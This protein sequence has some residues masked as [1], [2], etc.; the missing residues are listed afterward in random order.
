MAL[1]TIRKERWFNAGARALIRATNGQVKDRYRCPTCL[2]D[3]EL[4]A[5]RTGAITE[6]DVPPR[7]LGGRPMLLTCRPCNNTAGRL[8][9]SN[10]DR[11]EDQIRF[12]EGETLP[13]PLRIR[14]RV[15]EAAIRANL[16]GSAASGYIIEGV[17]A[18]NPP[19][20]AEVFG[21]A[22]ESAGVS[23]L[24][25]NLEFEQ[26]WHQWGATLCWVRAA[27]LLAFAAFGYRYILERPEFDL[28]RQQ[29]Q[30]PGEKL[31]PETSVMTAVG[32][33]AAQTLM[34]VEEPGDLNGA[35]FVEVGRR[36]VLLPGL[37]ADPAFFH[38]THQALRAHGV[39]DGGMV[40]V[41]LAGKDVPWPS[42]GP[43][44]ALD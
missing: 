5:L 34:L 11:R 28:L 22:L 31:M 29:L 20:A 18:A 7:A 8:L 21:A 44:Y 43:K 38:R 39:R 36:K 32:S 24:E 25:V 2:S 30:S 40:R 41:Q 12:I 42:D 23:G 10:A 35:L 26:R 17:P 1:R 27:Y 9:D 19:G 6:E 33:E 37:N 16:H 3:F 14:A 15:G 4:D 13:G